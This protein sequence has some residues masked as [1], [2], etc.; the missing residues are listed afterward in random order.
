MRSQFFSIWRFLTC[1]WVPF[2]L[3]G[4]PH[5]TLAQFTER[6]EHYEVHMFTTGGAVF[7]NALSVC[8]FD[9]DGLDDISFG[10]TDQSPRFYRNTG[11]GFELISF[12]ISTPA[13]TIKA[14]LW[15]D[16]DNDGD[17]DL[18]ISFEFNAVRIYENTGNMV[19]V[20]VTANSGLVMESEFRN[21]GASFGDYNND[22]FLDLYLCKYHSSFQFTGA[23][24]ENK[25]YRNNGNF[26]FTEVTAEANASVGVNPSFM[27]SW[28]DYNED[29]WQDL[30]IANDRLLFPN[31]LLQNNG[32]GTFTDVSEQAGVAN[33]MDAMGIGFGDFNNDLLLD[34]FV[35]NTQ[36]NKNHLYKH[37]ADH[38][39]ENIAESAGV[40]S[41]DLCWSGLWFD[42][43]NNG[44]LDLHVA[45]EIYTI[46]QIPSNLFY[47]NNQDETFSEAASEVG[48]TNDDRTTYA[49]AQGDWNMDGYPDFVSHNTFPS[50]SLLWENDGGSNHFIALTLTGVISNRDAVGTHLYCYADGSA[51]MRY[52][53]CGEAYLAQNS[54]RQLFG[55]GETE[56]VDSLVIKWLSGQVDR[57]YNL[58]A[59]SNYH[60]VEGNGQNG[61]IASDSQHFCAGDSLLL[62]ANGGVNTVWNTG[63]SGTD[64]LWVSQPGIYYYSAES[65]LGLPFTSLPLTVQMTDFSSLTVATTPPSCHGEASGSIEIM[66]NPSDS[67]LFFSLNDLPVGWATGGLEAGQYELLVSTDL[68]CAEVFNF[69]MPQPDAIALNLEINPI[70]CSG[71]NGS[72]FVAPIG[73]TGMLMVDWG[74]AS[75]DLLLAGEYTVLVTDEMGCSADTTFSVVEP[76]PL[77]VDVTSSDVTL[78]ADGSIELTIIGGSP[79]YAVSWTGPNAFTSTSLTLTNLSDGVYTA[80]V[81]DS[82]GCVT[83]QAVAILPLGREE[84]EPFRI[85]VYPNPSSGEIRVSCAATERPYFRLFDM[86]GRELALGHLEEENN[87]YTLN[88]QT[89]ET[90]QYILVVH[91]IGT[92]RMKTEKL[93]IR[94]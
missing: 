77:E 83:I 82:A 93:Q 64:S 51:Q 34:V 71:E 24:Y 28:F 55:L 9:G 92:M 81:V 4:S 11:T 57:Y 14:L 41:N 46:G 90:G 56:V 87:L 39:F 3:L 7:G 38:H 37:H 80:L 29:G 58:Q 88:L 2:T 32:D 35:P 8:D 33:F 20:D 63:V 91:L 94:K 52:T 50:A 27:A 60:F 70:P 43:D 53:A 26:T 6:H 42:Y 79:P 12:G 67:A 40:E 10:T 73:G 30:F 66:G 61:I 19:L 86:R 85:H 44:W 76:T 54:R 22:G 49:T 16:V 36:E 84:K 15:A 89:L 78:E 68:G 13:N 59:D 17:Q 23:Q 74:D 18:F 45:T 1:C 75:N 31:F 47:I 65:P 62:V 69:I 21:A 5:V 48:L 25:L 72:A